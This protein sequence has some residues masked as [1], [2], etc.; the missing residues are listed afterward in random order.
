ME[1]DIALGSAGN[2]ALKVAAGVA[3]EVASA[4]YSHSLFSG[5]ITIKGTVSEEVDADLV[6]L[7]NLVKALAE[8]K[9]PAGLKPI[10]EFTF[11]ELISLAQS[12]S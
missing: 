2:L 10:E 4:S 5:L 8:A 12:L 6:G 1:K 11:A 7:L 9:L 3:S